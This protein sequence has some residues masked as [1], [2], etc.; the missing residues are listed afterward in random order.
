MASTLLAT[1]SL[2]AHP[3]TTAP[4]NIQGLMESEFSAEVYILLPTEDQKCGEMIFFH[5]TGEVNDNWLK[6]SPNTSEVA[7]LVWGFATTILPMDFRQVMASGLL[8]Q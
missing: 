5:V 4:I 8:T 3:R 7:W 6:S 2:H 1:L